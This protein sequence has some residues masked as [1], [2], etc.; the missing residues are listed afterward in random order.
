MENLFEVFISVVISNFRG[1]RRD[2][3]SNAAN[4]HVP[5]S[6]LRLQ[7]RWSGCEERLAAQYIKKY[8]R[9]SPSLENSTVKWKNHPVGDRFVEVIKGI[10]GADQQPV[11]LKHWCRAVIRERIGEIRNNGSSF[12]I[13]DEKIQGLNIPR[14]VKDFVGLKL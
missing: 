3:C 4:V 10:L 5:L 12:F 1:T 7:S 2:L 11:S 9:S 8:E 6:Q 13:A 14:D